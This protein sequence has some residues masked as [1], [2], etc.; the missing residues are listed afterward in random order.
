M[1]QQTKNQIKEQLSTVIEKSGMSRNKWAIANGVSSANVSQIINGNTEHISDEMWRKFANAIGLKSGWNVAE[2]KLYK[3]LSRTIKLAQRDGIS[4]G[5][6]HNAGAGKT[7]TC[8][9]Y[10]ENNKNVFYLNCQEDL[11]KKTFMH[12]LATSM[13]LVV[14]GLKT[15]E[16]IDRV[17]GHVLVTERPV[18]IL[19]EADKL[20]DRVL[21]YYITLYNH[22]DGR[23][24]F[25]LIG[26]PH[27]Q[28]KIERGARR[29][30]MGYRE[31]YSRIGK[32][33]IQLDPINLADVEAICEENGITEKVEVTRIF[34]S[35]DSDL[36]R[37][38]REIEKLKMKN[39]K[40]AA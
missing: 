13:G 16:I 9:D 23:C 12:K 26:T 40:E 29:D 5:V 25:L 27:L 36:R 8:R 38:R 4:L 30:K 21:M 11:T 31:I 17:I 10:K 3:V 19:D 35:C 37:V 18:I 14:E 1:N 28:N 20:N 7:F 24:A 15:A 33:F 39:E 34:N 22:L 32:K 6:A 2:T